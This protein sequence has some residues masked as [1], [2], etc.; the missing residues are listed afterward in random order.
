MADTFNKKSVQQKKTKKKQDKQLRREDRK[1]NNDKG[2]S[3]DDMIAYLDEY[4]NITDTPP[5]NKKRAKIN[6][7][8]IQL[9]AAPAVK[10]TEIT[11]V[12]L[13]FFSDKAYGFIKDD[14]TGDTIFVHSNNF[15][16]PIKERDKVTFER[17]KTPKGFAAINV[18]KVVKPV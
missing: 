7:E 15:L 10:E 12:L 14:I 5:E 2:K 9:G 16:E 13:S 8:D 18:R 1:A 11:G 4:G 6:V 17:E 3:L